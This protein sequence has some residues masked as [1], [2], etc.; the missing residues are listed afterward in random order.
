MPANMKKLSSKEIYSGRLLRLVE[1]RYQSSSGR[2]VTREIV[3]HPGA[4]AIVP[5][6]KVPNEKRIVLVR[7]FRAPVAGKLWEIPAG[8]IE[9]GETP[10]EC[11]KRELKEETGLGGGKWTKLVSFYSSP[12]FTDEKI[13]LFMGEELEYQ[14]G[15]K[16]E[17]NL[18]VGEFSFDDLEDMLKSGKIVDSKTLIG[19]SRTRKFRG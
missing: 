8:K 13:N 9:S 15:V 11:A 12:G 16:K 10:L 19:I 18:E 2:T 4:A 7:Q 1:D 5:I 14:K 3:H 6:M 17:A